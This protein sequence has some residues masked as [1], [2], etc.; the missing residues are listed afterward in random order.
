ME[1][2]ALSGFRVPSRHRVRTGSGILQNI[3]NAVWETQE[4]SEVQMVSTAASAD[5]P[6]FVPLCYCL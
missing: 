1:F 6:V 4:K 2:P 5:L 3:L